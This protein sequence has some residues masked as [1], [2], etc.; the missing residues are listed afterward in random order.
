M[1]RIT[2]ALL[3][4]IL[5]TGTLAA[6]AQDGL[7][8]GEAVASGAP[9]KGVADGGVNEELSSAITDFGF[10]LL[11]RAGAEETRG[12]NTVVSPLSVHAALTMAYNGA[13]AKTKR[14]MESTLRLS[15]L[16]LDRTNAAYANLLASLNA[17]GED[18]PTTLDIA[19]SLWVDD[20]FTLRPQF[21]AADRDYFGAQLEVLDLPADGAS[22]INGWVANQTNGR[23]TD[24]LDEA[25]ADAALYLVNAVYMKG[26]WETP[27]RADATSDR[28][29]ATGLAQVDVPTMSRGGEMRYAEF[30]GTQAVRLPYKDGRLGMWILLPPV[31]NGDPSGAVDHELERLGGAAW[32]EL[33]DTATRR[34][35]YLELP[36]FTTRTKIELADVLCDMGMP[37]A[38]EPEKADFSGIHMGDDPLWI[39][40]VLHQTH[41]SVEET[42]TEAAAATGVETLRGNASLPP[43]DWFEMLVNRPFLFAIDDSETGTLLFL[44]KIEDPRR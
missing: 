1:H 12:T 8:I 13:S 38:F 9:I 31:V 6:C 29:F 19:N 26:D 11:N 40:R 2:L 4:A 37:S 43:K 7:K 3:L 15:A 22:R 39:S 25:P 41:V 5:M 17:L 16:G 27:F 21:A 10:D 33:T 35:G 44:G 28:P 18:G 23:I 42:G 34:S 14:E 20:G 24:L 36:K 32:S 30:N